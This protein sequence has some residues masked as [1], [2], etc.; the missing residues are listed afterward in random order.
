LLICA[1]GLGSK[2]AHT[3]GLTG[4]GLVSL[5]LTSASPA[6]LLHLRSFEVPA[7]GDWASSKSGLCS[8]TRGR[9]AA[10]AE[11]SRGVTCVLCIR[12]GG[13]RARQTSLAHGLHLDAVRPRSE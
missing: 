2:P 5:D 9:A 4:D 11:I 10:N 3:Q 6:M 1:Q 7:D 12:T 8:F 13:L